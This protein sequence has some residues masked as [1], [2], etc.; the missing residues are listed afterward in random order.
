[1][2]GGTVRSDRATVRDEAVTSDGR[3]ISQPPLGVP[4]SATVHELGRNFLQNFSC[5]GTS[6]SPYLPRVPPSPFQ[7]AYLNIYVLV[8]L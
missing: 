3:E 7:Q 8:L 1:M 6:Y 4:P 5:F 2:R